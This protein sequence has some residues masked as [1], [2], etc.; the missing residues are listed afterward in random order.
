MH[1]STLPRQS[2][3]RFF[4][5]LLRQDCGAAVHGSVVQCIAAPPSTRACG[6]S[7]QGVPCARVAHA[8]S[9][10]HSIARRLGP[11]ARRG[12]ACVVA[13]A[14]VMTTSSAPAW[15]RIPTA[16]PS[17]RQQ[18][19]EYVEGQRIP[20]TQEDALRQMGAR[21]RYFGAQECA[22]FSPNAVHTPAYDDES[23]LNED[24]G[25]GVVVVTMMVMVMVMVVFVVAMLMATVAIKRM[26]MMPLVLVT[27]I[28]AIDAPP[29]THIMRHDDGRDHAVL[30]QHTTCGVPCRLLRRQTSPQTC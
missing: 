23:P 16:M 13:L 1:V 11:E 4:R 3:A 15:A 7:A 27:M 10:D 5:A 8:S 6:H 19:E 29:A 25:S 9:S 20:M 22:R 2:S 18:Q 14:L 26:A 21:C 30:L 28:M 24:D 12:A 17:P